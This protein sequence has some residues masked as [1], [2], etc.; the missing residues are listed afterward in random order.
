[1]SDEANVLQVAMKILDYM[2]RFPDA[3]D[4]EEHITHW[5]FKKG[6]VEQEPGG[7]ASA[8]H[9]LVRNELI[10]RV[11]LPDNRVVYRLRKIM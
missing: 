6:D 9:M 10:E 1:M 11:E 7:V 4:T 8:L 2:R 5:W 3:A